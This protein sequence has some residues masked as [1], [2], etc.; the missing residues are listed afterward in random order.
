MVRSAASLERSRQFIGTN[1]SL[2]RMV[3]DKRGTE[4]EG[5]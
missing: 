1:P 5:T 3:V 2:R 4:A